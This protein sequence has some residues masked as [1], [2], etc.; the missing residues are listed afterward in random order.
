M[1][2]SPQNL[3]RELKQP[4]E[5]NWAL[6]LKNGK[7]AYAFLITAIGTPQLNVTQTRNG[8]H[9]LFIIQDHGTRAEV[10]EKFVQTSSNANKRIRSTAVQLAIGLVRLS[11]VSAIRGKVPA[12]LSADQNET[13]RGALRL[14]LTRKVTELAQNYLSTSSSDTGSRS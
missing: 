6:E 9:A 11:A 4:G 13:L 12:S 1:P 14:G 8:L 7:E 10:L 2:F 5:F 3:L